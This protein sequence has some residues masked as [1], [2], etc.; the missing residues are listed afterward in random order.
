MSQPKPQQALPP[1]VVAWPT[2][3]PSDVFTRIIGLLRGG[4]VTSPLGETLREAWMV[5]GYAA[6]KAF[7]DSPTPMAA[8]A[9]CPCP[10]CPPEEAASFLE[11]HA[12]NP[13]F[14]VEAGGSGKWL[15]IIAA[16]IKA[17]LPLLVA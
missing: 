15:G 2:S 5:I 11:Q 10:P 8:A 9:Q 3:L 16:I 7:P 12:V 13:S 17:L 6:G 1:D 14:G 4:A